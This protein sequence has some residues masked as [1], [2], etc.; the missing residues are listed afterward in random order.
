MS[1]AITTVTTNAAAARSVDSFAS[2]LDTYNASAH[3]SG[4]FSAHYT[5][6]SSL[7]LLLNLIQF[8]AASGGP[9]T[10]EARGDVLPRDMPSMP[11]RRAASLSSSSGSS[12]KEKVA[13]TSSSKSIKRKMIVANSSPTPDPEAT[14]TAFRKQSALLM[15]VS[16]AL[17]FFGYEFARSA[18]LSLFTSKTAGFSSPGAFPL[19]MACVSPFSFV[20]LMGYGREL[21]LRGPRAALR[22]TGLFCAAFLSLT[23]GGA[24]VLDNASFALP[25]D[26]GCEHDHFQLGMLIPS[27]IMIWTSFIFQQS[28]AHLLYTQH[29]SFLGSVLTSA[30][31]A[32]YFSPIAGLSSLS[33]ALAGAI[34]GKIVDK[35]GL[36]GLLG[37][38][39]ASLLLSVLL[40]DL[41]Y[42][43]SEKHDFDPAEEM[44]RK[45]AEKDKLSATKGQKEV[46]LLKKTRDMFDRVPVLGALFCEVISFQSLATILNVCMVTRLKEALTDDAVR[47][48]WTGRFYAYVNG[49]SGL[50]QFVLLPL[51]LKHGDITWIWRTMP[52]LPLICTLITSMQASHASL[53]LLAFSFFATKVI[54]YA[55]RN[56]LS[57]MVYV[58][59]D[60][61][62][63][64]L[65][66]E[67][68]G[69]FGNRFGKSGISLVL[70]GLGALF[71]SF[72]VSELTKIT[73]VTG[74][75]WF[76]FA[77]QLSNYIPSLGVDDD[78]S[79]KKKR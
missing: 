47:A 52:L 21:S 33:S 34:V 4:L 68:I 75:I 45:K 53:N 20:L 8:W 36:G 58:P 46:G 35:S 55:L 71:G 73:S 16:M 50:L 32:S 37:I 39:S 1:A 43:L 69:V 67:L 57:E 59:L 54:D 2:S 65:G 41:A 9:S 7:A 74:G 17:H 30:E 3:Y 11:Y 62:S 10:I 51:F 24:S 12:P 63:R 72:G 61:D 38:A 5:G 79:N 49:V 27:K 29:W 19:A 78:A 44:K 6:L 15:S 22:N 28:Y 60:F 42:G 23:G 31:G 40:S 26:E 13:L 18:N 64:Y 14:R 25:L 76:W 77:Y 66:K 48:A 70:S 56:V